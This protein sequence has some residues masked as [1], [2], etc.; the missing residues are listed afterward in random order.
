VTLAP[1]LSIPSPSSPLIAEIGPLKI[2]WYG[3]LIA[4]GILIAGWI[5]ERELQRRG[6]PPGRSYTIAMWCV[7]GGVIGAR[8]YHVAT[9]WD[10]FSGHLERIPLLQQGGLGLPGVII[11]GAIG[12]AIGAR[13]ARIPVLEVFDVIAPGP[14]LAQA[15]GRWGN[16][17]NQELFGGPTDLPWGL[18]ID[19]AHRPERYA[20][21]ATFHPTFLYESL[22]NLL[23]F[24]LLLKLNRRLW[25]RAP[26]GTV[27]SAY[28]TLYAFGRFWVE[29]LRVD[30][31]QYLFGVRFNLLLFGVVFLAAGCWF[32]WNLR[33]TRPLS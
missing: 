2:R 9:D 16:Y 15:L 21:D 11:G 10:R 29:S 30:P 7:P 33:R 20:A 12:A 4:I 22:W 31:A 6:Y 27:F 23:V 13:R 17:F 3:T 14:I 19:P 25:L 24:V 28:L 18:E 32:I 5:A 26:N 8:L 1:L